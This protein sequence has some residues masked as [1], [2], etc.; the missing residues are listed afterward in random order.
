MTAP[1]EEGVQH[2][3]ALEARASI[4]QG[5]WS[6]HAAWIPPVV[7]WLAAKGTA[8]RGPRSYSQ[9]CLV[10]TCLELG[11]LSAKLW[12]VLLRAACNSLPRHRPE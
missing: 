12:A 1:Q 6:Y 3:H 4:A 11:R 9:H 7:R 2:F 10:D 8:I 5:R